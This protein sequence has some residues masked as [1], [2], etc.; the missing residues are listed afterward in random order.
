MR[1]PIVSMVAG[2]SVGFGGAAA[3]IAGVEWLAEEP[4]VALAEIGEPSFDA[5]CGTRGLEMVEVGA[6]SDRYHCAGS[7][8]GVWT[9]TPVD[10]DVVC[11]DQYGTPARRS[12]ET[13]SG[14]QCVASP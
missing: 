14:W 8:S 11:R 1:H 5:Y 13:S 9:L 4:P 2:L 10:V 6:G 7:A 12:S 3:T